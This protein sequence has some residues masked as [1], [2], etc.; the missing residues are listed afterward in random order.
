MSLHRCVRAFS[1]CS[2]RGYSLVV[3]QELLVTVASLLAAGRALGMQ[4]SVFAA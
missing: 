3:V 4:A 2:A 1:S